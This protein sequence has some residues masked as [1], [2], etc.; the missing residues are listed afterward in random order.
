MADVRIDV[1]PAAFRDEP[2]DCALILGSGWGEVLAPEAVHAVVPYAELPDFG[3]ASVVGHRG[4]LLLMTLA[5]RRVA[6]FSGRRHYYEGCSL[7][8][9]VYPIRLLKTLG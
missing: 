6:V 7:E 2:I 5:G 4:E 3:A 8:Q 9:I 1:L